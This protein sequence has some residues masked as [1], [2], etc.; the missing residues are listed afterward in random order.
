MS[1]PQKLMDG[2]KEKNLELSKING[3]LKELARDK[4]EAE[5]EYRI[6]RMKWTLKLREKDVAVTITKDIVRGKVATEKFDY[7]IA[8]ETYEIM[9]KKAWDLRT[10]IETYR[11][12]LSWEKAEFQQSGIQDEMQNN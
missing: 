12:L 6:A 3:E 10:A 8:T 11:S 9:K 5:K 1:N 7:D 4:A 2:L